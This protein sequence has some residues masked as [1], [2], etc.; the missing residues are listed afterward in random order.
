MVATCKYLLQFVTFWQVNTKQKKITDSKAKGDVTNKPKTSKPVSPRS[1]S[2]TQKCKPETVKVKSESS[3]KDGVKV[4]GD[5]KSKPEVKAKKDDQ[6][7]TASGGKTLTVGAKKERR[8]STDE[9]KTSSTAS[10]DNRKRAQSSS[11]PAPVS[12]AWEGQPEMRL[13]QF[14]RVCMALDTHTCNTSVHQH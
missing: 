14:V 11:T 2:D 5:N 8:R 4:K 3:K 13:N 9:R 6:K 7:M 12:W 1:K 10:S